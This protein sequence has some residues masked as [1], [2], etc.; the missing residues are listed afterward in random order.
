MTGLTSVVYTLHKMKYQ[1]YYINKDKQE[2]HM[3]AIDFLIKEHNKV[4]AML[5]D[6]SDRSHHHET[7]KKK[8]TLLAQDLLRHETM[9]HEVWYPH[10]RNKLSDTVKHLLTEEKGAEKAIKKLD[11]LKTE[12]AWEENFLKFKH[13]VEH[14]AQEEENNLFPEVEKILSDKELDD[15]GMKMYEF[16]KKHS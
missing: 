9:E 6:M 1:Q 14:H 10:F 5:L 16:K 7:K 4:R 12:E 3:N 8:F 13:D 15:I 2:S 11:S